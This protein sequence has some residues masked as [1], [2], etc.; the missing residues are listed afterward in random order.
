M[1]TYE[2]T[3]AGPPVGKGRPRFT[4]AGI[5]YTPGKTAN[6]ENLIR[7]AFCE[8]YGE[9]APSEEPVEIQVDGY[10]PIAKSWT[11]KKKVMALIGL[12]KNT[13]K[14]DLDNI[15]KSALD[16]LNGVAFQDD[17]QVWRIIA[18]KRYSD[19]PRMEI[20]MIIGQEVQA[21]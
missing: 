11:K 7:L 2:L 13:S 17:K 5:A 10:F 9:D 8:K 12:M 4:K 18:S 20:K 19:R 14:P 21:E 3:V 1:N 15:I 16:G 6:Y